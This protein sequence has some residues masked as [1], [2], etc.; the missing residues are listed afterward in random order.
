[1]PP[2][3]IFRGIIGHVSGGRVH[4]WEHKLRHQPFFEEIASH[5]ET[6]AEW[7]SATAGLVVLRLLDAWIE[8]GTQVVPDDEWALRSVRAAV[9]AIDSRN[10]LRSIL[11]SVLDVLHENAA[12]DMRLV[13][14][15]LMAYG[16]LLEYE[17]QWSMAS[18][19]YETIISHTHPHEDADTATQ[20]HLRRG[21]CLR[22][23]GDMAASVAAYHAA[24]QIA[25]AVN[26]ME[27]VLR[28]RI[29]EAKTALAHG[30][31]PRAE[32]ILDE[33][34][35]RASAHNL[36]DVRSMALHDRATV[37]GERGD[38]ELSIRLAYEALELT[39]ATRERDR[40]LGDIAVSFHRLGIRS[41]ARD[42]WLIL[43]ATAQEQY[44]RWQSS[45]NLMEVS[46]EEGDSVMFESYRRSVPV[47]KLPPALA[48]NYWL[49]GGVALERLGRLEDARE[50]LEC[51]IAV[52][53]EFEFHHVVFQA[54][55]SLRELGRREKAM[56]SRAASVLPL[57]LQ[58]VADRITAE[59]DR[60]R[61]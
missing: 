34:I 40:I 18:D 29:G 32:S 54:E 58:D 56:Q 33:A 48:T 14:P 15:R 2:T 51:A 55:A 12:A 59:R 4:R 42:A 24:E 8:S 49:Q 36:T 19:V 61:V 11:N 53:E 35:Q 25:E 26:D 39:Q 60:L 57:D 37:A 45:L 52:A 13:G 30:N 1:V 41:A 22:H 47:S 23:I 28:A 27:G 31:L 43:A 20:A 16:Q 17:S 38:Y 21:F 3:L 5:E 46:A 7:K 6:D 44:Q 9:D 10:N 50:Y